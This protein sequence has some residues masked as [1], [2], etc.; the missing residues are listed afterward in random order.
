M[1]QISALLW[2]VKLIIKSSIFKIM[3]QIELDKMD[4]A[5][6][7]ASSQQTTRQSEIIS[8]VFGWDNELLLRF[9]I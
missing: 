3:A 2:T 8:K 1:Y 4:N 7:D 5:V 6:H 9:T